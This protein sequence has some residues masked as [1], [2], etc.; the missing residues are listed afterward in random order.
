MASTSST[1]TPSSACQLMFARLTDTCFNDESTCIVINQNSVAVKNYGRSDDMVKLYPYADVAGLRRVDKFMKS[2]AVIEDWA[3]EGLPII[4]SPTHYQQ[5]PTIA[6]LINQFGIGSSFETNEVAK[7][8]VKY[9]RH[10]E[11]VTRLTQDTQ[12]RRDLMFSRA[13]RKLSVLLSESKFDHINKIVIPIGIA[14]CGVVDDLWL[15]SYLPV[16]HAFS[17]D[18]AK[19][20]KQVIIV[21]SHYVKS[22]AD[23][24]F[25]SRKGSIVAHYESLFNLPVITDVNNDVSV[26][27]AD[28]DSING[29]DIPDTLQHYLL[30]CIYE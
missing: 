9:S 21:L 17:L 18:M 20:K 15:S 6:T 5:G 26:S 29:E 8:I 13:L 27:N 23:N 19:L 22:V 16:I 30:N 3:D 10:K 1:S 14:R 24:E 25:R 12:A 4:K 2:V 28:E 11:Y 7:K